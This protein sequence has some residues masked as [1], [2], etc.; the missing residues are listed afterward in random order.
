[1]V[2]AGHLTGRS[3][4][5]DSLSAGFRCASPFGGNGRVAAGRRAS[6]IRPLLAGPG[7][8]ECLCPGQRHKP[9]RVVVRGGLRGGNCFG[10]SGFI[11]WR[12]QCA[13]GRQGNSRFARDEGPLLTVTSPS[14]NLAMVADVGIDYG[15]ARGLRR[16]AL[17]RLGAKCL[18]G[19]AA[20]AA[21]NDRGS[22]STGGS[23]CPL[24]SDSRTDAPD[25]CAGAG[26]AGANDSQSAASNR[27]PSRT[28][29]HAAIA[30]QND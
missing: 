25:L 6:D 21:A 27:L 7:C 29:Q 22:G 3:G 15:A 13:L 12:S 20:V 18:L 10:W 14:K 24:S 4:L 11:Y 1:M 19:K 26:V 5:G 17:S 9:Q 30:L 23:L 16:V 28:Q 8:L 2:F